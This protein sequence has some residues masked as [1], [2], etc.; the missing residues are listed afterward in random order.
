MRAAAGGVRL[1]V[2]LSPRARADRLDAIAQ[3]ADG[4]PVLRASVTAVPA[5]GRANTALLRLLAG[6]L[7]VPIRD[8]SLVGGLKSRTKTVAIAGDAA[9]LL[10][11]LDAALAALPRA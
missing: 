6:A 1:T 11:R 4:T 7:D 5:D 8:L 3:L 2:R 10:R 9:S